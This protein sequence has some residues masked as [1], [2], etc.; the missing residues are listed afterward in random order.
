MALASIAKG[1][2]W[3]FNKS[4]KLTLPHL[5][6]PKPNTPTPVHSL[7][8]PEA[9]TND[10]FRLVFRYLDTDGNG[11]I[12]S[13]EL[14]AYFASMGESMS[15]DEAQSVV[16]EFD[17]D[18]DNLLEFAEFVKLMERESEGEDDDIRRAFEMFEVEKGSGCITPR[19]LQQ[20]LNRLGKEK[21]GEDCEAMIRAFD[22]DG[23]G[24]LDFYEF[25]KMMTPR[26]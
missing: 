14:Q 2:K 21:S 8:P 3:L 24:V 16:T 18:G 22:L 7:L 13:D 15:S 17:K 19:G 1:S 9:S 23:N 25:N 10:E 4:L 20:V 11:K 12:S 6:Q 26:P 5:H